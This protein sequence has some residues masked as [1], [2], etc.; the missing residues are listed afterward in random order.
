MVENRQEILLLDETSKKSN[1]KD[2]LPLIFVGII[3]FIFILIIILSIILFFNYH[4]EISH[5]K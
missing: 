4:A 2:H 5:L 3:I 1:L